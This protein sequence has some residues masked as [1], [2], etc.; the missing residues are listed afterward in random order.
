MSSLMSLRDAS[1][2]TSSVSATF[3]SL[4]EGAICERVRQGQAAAAGPFST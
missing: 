3:L 1:K 4:L 2:V